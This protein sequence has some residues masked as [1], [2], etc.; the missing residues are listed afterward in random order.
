MVLT[1]ALKMV[2]RLTVQ[3][4]IHWAGLTVCCLVVT[5]VQYW[6]RYWAAQTVMLKV[7]A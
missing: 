3:T 2:G 1:M 7:D 4:V 5:R 6:A